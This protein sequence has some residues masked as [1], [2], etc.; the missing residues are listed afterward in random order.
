M[1]SSFLWAPL[2]QV[3]GQFPESP[4]VGMGA[5]SQIEAG[6]IWTAMV[7]LPFPLL[8]QWPAWLWQQDC[9]CAGWCHGVLSDGS[10]HGASRI[11]AEAAAWSP[12]TMEG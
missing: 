8:L 3:C 11:P 12:L 7:E 9:P 10:W 1:A 4:V 5:G 2:F 6:V